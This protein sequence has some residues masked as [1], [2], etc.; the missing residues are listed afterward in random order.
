MTK[1]VNVPLTVDKKGELQKMGKKNQPKKRPKELKSY[2]NGPGDGQGP[3]DEVPGGGSWEKKKKLQKNKKSKKRKKDDAEG[4][5]NKSAG[6]HQCVKGE[7]TGNLVEKASR[8]KGKE[9][10]GP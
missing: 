7:H 10:W 8:N 3:A 2:I 5:G 4:R 1:G 6:R 9:T